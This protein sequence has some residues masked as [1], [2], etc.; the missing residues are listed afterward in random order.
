MR[1]PN[2]S[3]CAHGSHAR[4]RADRTPLAFGSAGIA[5]KS[6]VDDL[7]R[8]N[9]RSLPVD[10]L[11]SDQ[12]NRS[13]SSVARSHVWKNPYPKGSFARIEAGLYVCSPELMFIQMA[14]TFTEARLMELGY[15]LCGWYGISSDGSG[16]FKRSPLTSVEDLVAYASA[17]STLRGTR[18]ALKVLP[19]VSNN[20]AS[21]MESKLAA[22]L[23]MPCKLGGYGLPLPIMNHKVDAA[24]RAFYLDLC[25]PDS[26]IGG[27][28]DSRLFHTGADRNI[29]DSQRR[30]ALA[31]AGFDI[32]TITAPEIRNILALD[33]IAKQFARALGVPTRERSASYAVRQENLF[34]ELFAA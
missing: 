13:R 26:H 17:N 28:Y 31:D 9:V 30:N 6:F 25:W 8:W 19:Y 34:R 27:E 18:K 23:A 20:S 11:V 10:T 29:H 21:P 15:E 22:L 12:I 32:V 5:T 1:S 3:I 14:Q 4:H 24:G 7:S 2:A 33:G 16:M